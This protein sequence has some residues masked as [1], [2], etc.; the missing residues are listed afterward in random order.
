MREVE[1]QP[2]F[3][4]KRTFLGN[5]AAEL[6]AQSGMHQVGCRVIGADLVAARVIDF[7]L[8]VI[9]NRNLTCA[10]VRMVG[11]QAPQRLACIGDRGSE[12]GRGADRSGITGLTTAFS[13]ERG[14]V[15]Q[16]DDLVALLCALHFCAV[17]DDR[18]DCA[19]PG[20][21]SVT[22]ELRR[23]FAF[24]NIEPDFT[25]SRLA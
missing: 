17:L 14:L 12:A 1:T 2:V 4:N 3:G 18:N 5:M 20:G 11:V 9:A 15:G 16:D 22:G 23:P 8:H 25:R 21:G 7:K 24:G 10:D 6:I 13:V 19:F